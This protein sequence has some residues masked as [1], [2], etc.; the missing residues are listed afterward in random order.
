MRAAYNPPLDL[1]LSNPIYTAKEYRTSCV[2][3]TRTLLEEAV[4]LNFFY[5]TFALGVSNA[6]GYTLISE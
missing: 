5:N 6:G 4:L 2:T 1:R 3:L